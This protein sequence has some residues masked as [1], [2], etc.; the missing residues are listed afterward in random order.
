VVDIEPGLDLFLVRDDLW[1][2][3]PLPDLASHRALYRPFNVQ[4]DGA[5]MPD[6]QAPQAG[7]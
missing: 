2:G 6:Q 3:R 1:A 7:V 4:R 5:M